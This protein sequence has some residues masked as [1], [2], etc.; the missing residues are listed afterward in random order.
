[1]GSVKATDAGCAACDDQVR[2]LSLKRIVVGISGASG[3]V[4]ALRL[5]QRLAEAEE[6]QT[7]L[8]ATRPGEMTLHQETGRRIADLREL[9]HEVHHVERI[10]ATIASGSF[11]FEAM[12][13]VPCSMHTMA[14]IACGLASNLLTRAADVALKERRRLIL[15]VRETPLHLGHLRNMATLA[16]MG[17]IIAPPVPAFYMLPKTLDDIVEQHVV[18][19]LDLLGVDAEANRWS[20]M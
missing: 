14:S 7:H 1:M 10:G 19:M 16:E 8:V 11:L 18:R 4:Y 3:A 5:L 17:A 15:V 20:G 9:V 13:I 6:V 12:A 2:G